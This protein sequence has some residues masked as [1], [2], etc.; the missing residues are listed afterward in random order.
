MRARYL[1]GASLAALAAGAALAQADMGALIQGS[2]YPETEAHAAKTGRIVPLGPLGDVPVPPDNPMTDAKVELGRMLFFDERLSGNGTMPCSACHLP[3]AGWGTPDAISLGYPG[4]THW[5]NSQTILNSAY[6]NKYFWDGSKTSLEAQA[7]AA[8]GGAVAGN[9][10]GSIMEM[11]LAFIPEYRDRFR[12]VFGT[13][14]PIMGDAWRAISAFQRTIVS[15]PALVPFDRH[16]AGDEAALSEE[17]L[18]GLELFRG[19]AG[20]IACHSGPLLSDQGF[21]ALGVPQDPIMETDD[22]LQMITVRWENYAKGVTEEIY[23]SDPGDLGLYYVTKRPEDMH[24]FRVPSLR[25]LT[26]T[27]PYM[28]NGA[29]GT[30]AE[31]VEFYDAGGGETPNKSPL[32]RPLGLSEA[33]KAALVAF[34][35]SLSMDEPLLVEV[36][37]LPD[38]EP[39]R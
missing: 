15:D 20:C 10:D 26:W 22:P 19:E 13:D 6:Y 5:R 31:V 21:A 17:A 4:T 3:D 7:K 16:A 37:D 25:E 2:G 1:I 12:Q 8:A 11:R 35:E 24:K 30:L 36:P 14:Y 34:L 38:I 29:F 9:G 28:H 27:A 39:W 32:I 18:R 33:D 23:Y